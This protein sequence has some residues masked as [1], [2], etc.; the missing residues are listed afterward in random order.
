ME[1]ISFQIK[2]S[3]KIKNVPKRLFKLNKNDVVQDFYVTS[4]KKDAAGTLKVYI[5]SKENKTDLLLTTINIQ[6]KQTYYFKRGQIS[7]ELTPGKAI[8]LVSDDSTFDRKNLQFAFGLKTLD[9]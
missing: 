2:N 4:L 8:Y 1:F 7:L 5:G 6:S 3:K 9:N